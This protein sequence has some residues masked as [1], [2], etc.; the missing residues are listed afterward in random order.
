MSPKRCDSPRHSRKS[1]TIVGICDSSGLS[2]A[3]GL[4]R[5]VFAIVG[6]PG[7]GHIRSTLANFVSTRFWRA[8]SAG[9]SL[10]VAEPAR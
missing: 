2:G 3:G 8:R 9:A 5:F 7:I 10:L 6:S 4:A 1:G